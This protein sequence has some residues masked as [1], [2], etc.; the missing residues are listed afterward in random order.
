MKTNKYKNIL[1]KRIFFKKAKCFKREYNKEKEK[2]GGREWDRMRER[3]RGR[4]R[5]EGK[6]CLLAGYPPLARDTLLCWEKT[7]TSPDPLGIK[8]SLVNPVQHIKYTSST[9][10]PSL[11][12]SPCLYLSLLSDLLL[13]LARWLQKLHVYACWKPVHHSLP[14]KRWSLPVPFISPLI[15]HSLACP[16]SLH[17]SSLFIP[18]LL[19][20]P[21]VGGLGVHAKLW[22]GTRRQKMLKCGTH[23]SL[24]LL[25]SASVVRFRNSYCVMAD[26][27]N[28]EKREAQRRVA[29]YNAWRVL[30]PGQQHVPGCP[31]D[32]CEA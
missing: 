11:S 23:L 16:L 13:S 15:S 26:E 8:L 18:L 21:V 25:L 7:N 5:V 29:K 30:L 17:L 10:S 14:S 2:G 4:D 32:R 1:W 22:S 28:F 3:V 9:Q 20:E 31:G 12:L 19:S 24:S 6:G 27:F